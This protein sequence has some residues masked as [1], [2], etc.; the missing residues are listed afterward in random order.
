MRRLLLL[1]LLTGT[2]LAVEVHFENKD[3]G[4]F[5]KHTPRWNGAGPPPEPIG[6]A[7]P[8]ALLSLDRF[9]ILQG[10]APASVRATYG[11]F[12]TKQTVP[13]RYAVPDPL[14]P[15]KRNASLIELQEATAH[16]LDVSAHL[17]FREL[18]RDS[19]VL[20]V[21]FH[22]G[23]E[24]ARR[25]ASRPRRVCITLHASLGSKSLTATCGP[26]GEEGAC[27][28]ELTVPAAWWPADGKGKRPPRTVR[29]AYSAT[30]AGNG[31]SGED[32]CGRVSVQ[33][34]WPLGSVILAGARAG[35][36]EARAGD[37]AL[38]L[39]RAPLYPHSRIHLPFV[40]RRDSSHNIG[41]VAIRMKVKSGLRLLSVTAANSR[42]AVT[43]EVKMRSATVTATRLE[44]P[45]RDDDD[46]DF[47]EEETIGAGGPGWEEVLTW[48]VEVGPEG[49][50][51]AE[52]SEGE[53]G[54]GTARLSWSAKVSPII[55]SSSTTA[56]PPH[57][58]VNTRLDI[59]KDDIQ[60]VL[61]ISKNW[62]VLN[63]A[64]LTGR[65]VSQSMKVLIVSQ[66]GQVADVTLQSSCHSEDESV[67]KVSSSCS[68][69]YVDGSEIRG[70]SNASV[71]V[72]YGTYT[73]LARFT[74]WMPENPLE[75]DVDDNRLSQIKGWKVSDDASSKD[76]QRRSLSARGWGGS[77][78][79]GTNSLT[80][81]RSC[82]LRY[83]QSNVEVYARFLAKD[84][85]SGRVS[86]FVSRR[87]W[88]KVTEL[89]MSLMRVADLRIATLR[90][91]LL[92]GR[93]TGRTEVQVLSP[94]TGRVIG[95]REV[96]VGNDKVSISRLLVRVISGLQ[97]N[98][99]PDSAIENGY[100][101][102]TTVTRRLTAQYQEGLLDIDIEYSDGSH[103][104]LRDVAV[105]DYFLLVESLDPEVVA[106]APMLASKH[107]RV[108][109]VGEGSG[110]LL[111]VTLLT[112]EQCRSGP[113]RRV[114]L[115]GKGDAKTPANIKNIPGALATAAA[116]VDV[117]FSGGDAPQRPDTPQNDDI[118]ARGGL[119]SGLSDLSDVL[120]GISPFK[121]ENN[122][123]PTV[124]A[125][126]YNSIFRSNP[127]QHPRQH[128]STVMT[129]V[130][131]GMYVL[132]GAFCFAIVVFVVSCVVYASRLKP[133]GPEGGTGMC[134]KIPALAEGGRLQV[135]GLVGT[136]LGL[137]RDKPTRES[138]TNAHDWVWLGRA[139]MERSGNRHQANRNST[140]VPD[141]GN[142]E[143]RITANPLNYNYVDP[144]DAIRDNGNVMVTSFDNPNSI[145]LPSQND[146]RV[147]DSTTYCK[148]P[149]RHT[150]QSSGDGH[151]QSEPNNPDDYRPPVPPHRHSSTIQQS[152]L[153]VPP[154]NPNKIL[155][156]AVMPPA[157]RSHSRNHK[158]YERE[159]EPTK[160][161]PENAR[162]S[163]RIIDLN[164]TD[165]PY[166]TSRDI[167][168]Y[169][170]DSDPMQNLNDF[171]DNPVEKLT[172]KDDCARLFEFDNDAPLIMENKDYREIVGLNRGTD[173]SRRTFAKPESPDYMHDS[174]IG[175][176]D[177][178]IRYKNKAKEPK[179]DFVESAN[180]NKHR[181][182]YVKNKFFDFSKQLSRSE[183]RHYS[184]QPDVLTRGAPRPPRGGPGT[185]RPPHGLRSDHALFPQPQGIKSLTPSLHASS[186]DV[187]VSLASMSPIITAQF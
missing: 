29:L 20:R 150:R 62:E 64:V 108:I 60:A 73:G 38:L 46:I 130:E 96:R 102:E 33:P 155:P 106:F 111:R 81:Q 77:R 118:M 168:Q 78:S 169:K 4:F 147:I 95:V 52:G 53:S 37:A 91:K 21:L 28:A 178:Q 112:P 43:S 160:R 127:A 124:Q 36:R 131:I 1:F 76:R 82:R 12:S 110:E 175:L 61:P 49:E 65:Q 180:Q 5:L 170:R 59:E 162:R 32:T 67:L 10:S 182:Q 88:L 120:K 51:D 26:E 14:E 9:T 142:Q 34:A 63:T 58:R 172:N 153:P 145:E 126:H 41:H 55:S 80:D 181:F 94:I 166:V 165:A 144:D 163:D 105:S 184:R 84:H 68:S 83:Q 44:Q 171:D 179:G 107:P 66:A 183:T 135:A 159:H 42:W 129:P 185:R 156:E 132:L 101:S 140:Q 104:P 17:V 115:P 71:I 125:Q 157:R 143:I 167:S 138:T 16:R 22:T 121:D 86:Y 24:G 146:T 148:K 72:K 116:S 90:G 93:S 19:P 70:S 177:M 8:G 85:D 79:D 152:Q 164:K 137:A 136:T 151:W 139:T 6:T 39:P 186:V 97:L 31:E 48:L 27:L 30:E 99:S 23:G 133:A 100:V 114:A 89:V 56:E 109:A 2:G 54:R 103:T 98:I 18:P 149:A 7:L 47:D 15:P 25:A 117:D 50:G 40:V 87:T 176:P 3:S 134:R 11:P 122:H 74:V 113:I 187:A 154:R 119:R 75:I 158:K 128:Q 57:E 161:S 35:Y 123:E 92:Q 173:D 69:V 141:N 13:A 45:L 174:G